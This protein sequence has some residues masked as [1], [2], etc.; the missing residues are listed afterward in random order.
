MG[1]ALAWVLDL[2]FPAR[3]P[4]CLHRTDR[5]GVCSDCENAIV[6][7]VSPLCPICGECFAGAG[8][9]HRCARCLQRRRHFGRARACA[10]YRAGQTSPLIDALHRFKYGRDVTLAGP[11]GAYLTRHAPFPIDHDVVLPVPLHLE[12]LRWRGFNQSLLLADAVARAARR[13]LRRMALEKQRATPPQVGLDEAARRHNV[14][15]AFVA[16]QPAAVRGRTVLLIDDVMTTGATV[17]ECARTLRRAGARRVDVLVLA[18]A[19]ES[20]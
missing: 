19:A 1:G 17:D 5:V 10:L 12:R 2:I 15:G 20:A 7:A 13:P 8:P 4:I 18:R 14:R 6:P 3:C 9:D 16:R 11:L